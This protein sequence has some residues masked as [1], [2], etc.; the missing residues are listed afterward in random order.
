MKLAIV[1][2]FLALFNR[3]VSLNLR[4]L[5]ITSFISS[6]VS[7]HEVQ[8][9]HRQHIAICRK[10]LWVWKSWQWRRQN[11]H[12]DRFQSGRAD[13]NG[14]KST[15]EFVIQ[16]IIFSITLW[17]KPARMTWISPTA[18]R[19]GNQKLTHAKWT[20]GWRRLS[21]GFSLKTSKIRQ[22]MNS[23]ELICPK[24]S[25]TLKSSSFFHKVSIQKGLFDASMIF[26]Y[27]FIRR[28][29]TQWPTCR[30]HTPTSLHS[31]PQSFLRVESVSLSKMTCT[32][33][34]L[35]KAR[36]PSGCIRGSC[37]SNSTMREGIGSTRKRRNL[38]LC[39]FYLNQ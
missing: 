19:C 31:Q 18:W 2:I 34:L 39:N 6:T 32:E 27:L 15:E 5:S 10:L 1:F 20:T 11:K 23:S 28:E 26:R 22:T 29:S 13:R 3:S 37:T 14:N 30:S 9:V 7:N 4:P 8:Q 33:K 35:V 21:S 25:I 36:R 38:K 12:N 24:P 17:S 16:P